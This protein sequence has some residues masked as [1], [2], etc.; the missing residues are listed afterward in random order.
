MEHPPCSTEP[1]MNNIDD[2]RP[3]PS[4]VMRSDSAQSQADS[5]QRRMD[6]NISEPQ[7]LNKDP[8][9]NVVHQSNHRAKTKHERQAAKGKKE[10]IRANLVGTL[11]MPGD[12]MLG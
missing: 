10:V 7:N 11:D 1:P 4:Q 9:I 2:I 12:F 5:S 3:P 8:N 6:L